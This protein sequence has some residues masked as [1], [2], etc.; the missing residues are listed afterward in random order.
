MDFA[1]ER[2]T[3]TWSRHD[4]LSILTTSEPSLSPRKLCMTAIAARYC[5]VK[6]TTRTLS[7]EFALYLTG[8]RTK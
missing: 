8:R 6:G 4:G 3:Q 7:T 2:S 5:Q 1:H